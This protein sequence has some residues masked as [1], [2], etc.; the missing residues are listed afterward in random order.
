MTYERDNIRRMTAYEWGE[1][2]GS[3][4]VL[5]LNTNENP[6]PPSPAVQD[7]LNTISVERLRRYPPPTADRLRERLAE[8]HELSRDNIV[9]THGGDEGLRLAMT[10]FVEPGSGFGMLEPS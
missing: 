5:K 10:T 8:L 1:Q 6:Y 7:A 2:P 3:E 9:V 4:E